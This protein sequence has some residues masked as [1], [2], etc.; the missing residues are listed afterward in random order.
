MARVARGRLTPAI[1]HNLLCI[2]I[3]AFFALL[4][5][6]LYIKISMTVAGSPSKNTEHLLSPH[7]SA[8]ESYK[9]STS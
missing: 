7:L 8:D 2:Y 1:A 4:C 6:Y 9:H 3:L 5:C